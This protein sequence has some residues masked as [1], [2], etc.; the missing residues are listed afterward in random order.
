MMDLTLRTAAPLN[1]AV[2]GNKSESKPLPSAF[3]LPDDRQQPAGF[4]GI[5]AA[6]SF[7]GADGKP[8]DFT[9]PKQDKTP[10]GLA[11]RAEI[12]TPA[13]LAEQ[14]EIKT[15]AGLAEQAEGKT[16]AGLAEQAGRKTPAA[17]AELAG[18]KTPAGLAEQAGRKTPAGLA[19]GA[20]IKTPAVLAE[21]AERKTPAG[22]AEGAERKT[23]AALAERAERKTSAGLAERAERKSPAGLAERAER[24]S[25]AGLAEGAERKSPASL[26]E[27]AERTPPAGLA[28]RAER[29]TPGGLAEQVERKTPGGLAEQ[30]EV[31]GVDLTQTASTLD[32]AKPIPPADSAHLPDFIQPASRSHPAALIP[33]ENARVDLIAQVEGFT[34]VNQRTVQ[35]TLSLSSDALKGASDSD[36]VRDAIH[37][38]NANS[39]PLKNASFLG[40]DPA[41]KNTSPLQ[42]INAAANGLT[43]K[44][45]EWAKVDLHAEVQKSESKAATSSRIGEKLMAILQDRINIQASNNIKSAQ[46]RLDPP[47]LGH[48]KLTVAIEGDKVSVGIVSQNTVVREGLMQTSERLRHELVNQNFVDVSVD[49]SSGSEGQANKEQNSQEQ[50]LANESTAVDEQTGNNQDEFIAKV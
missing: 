19:E 11:E 17:L 22:L 25:P 43:E 10:A 46:I 16:P 32:A 38:S 5:K 49:I 27:G 15:P 40:T 39:L 21:G 42:G 28:E 13:G 47:D 2:S 7:R 23:P 29:K 14:A 31:K 9:A 45:I 41:Q 26:A 50:I 30:A 20:E 18:K 44:T 8:M 33:A 36:R 1:T 6:V 34:R 3:A 35:P 12:K 37:L 24:N 48:I 4:A